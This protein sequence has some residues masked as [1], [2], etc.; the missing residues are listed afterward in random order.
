M[1]TKYLL[2]GVAAA[3]ALLLGA[4]GTTTAATSSDGSQGM[5]AMTSMVSAADPVLPSI[6]SEYNDADIVFATDMIPHH[7]QAVEMAEMVP[8]SGASPE[9]AALAAQIQSAQQ[10]EVD[11][12]LGFLD[13]WGQKPPGHEMGHDMGMMSE[14]DMTTLMGTSG[15]EFDKM[16]LTMMTA[17]HD[18]AILMAKAELAAGSNPQAKDLATNIITAQQIEIDAMAALLK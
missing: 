8:G 18:G 6:S 4:C 2:T 14:A 9:V 7:I 12:M 16:W 5:G 3:A 17:H 13:T 10:P 15:G 11:L 1:D